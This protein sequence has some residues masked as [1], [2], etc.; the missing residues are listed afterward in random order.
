MNLEQECNRA[1][2][3]ARHLAC[4]SSPRFSPQCWHL[5][6]SPPN[7]AS[8]A[9]FRVSMVILAS[10]HLRP[11]PA[12]Y[13]VPRLSPFL[14]GQSRLRLSRLGQRPRPPLFSPVS[15]ACRRLHPDPPATIAIANNTFLVAVDLFSSART[16]QE[17]RTRCRVGRLRHRCWH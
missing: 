7:C 13:L 16:S 11:S 2:S 15:L 5:H 17:R 3:C 6:P 9:S 14:L 12:A 1:G 4:L 8:S 10:Q